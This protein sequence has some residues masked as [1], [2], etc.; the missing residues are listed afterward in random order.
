MK[1]TWTKIILK[2]YQPHKKKSKSFSF[3]Y[4]IPRWSSDI[5]FIM[6]FYTIVRLKKIKVENYK[7][8]NQVFAREYN[9]FMMPGNVMEDI[10]KTK[11][12][13][14]ALNV[15]LG[16]LPYRVDILYKTKK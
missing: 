1:S 7:S 11:N 13:S 9:F 8:K 4:Y 10:P 15:K 16:K 14:G 3:S 2:T 12:E 5:D 6:S